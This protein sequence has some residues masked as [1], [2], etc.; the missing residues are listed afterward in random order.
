MI[1]QDF[2]NGWGSVWTLKK[3]EQRIV[4]SLL[5]HIASDSSRTVVIF[6]RISSAGV[7]LAEI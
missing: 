7:S 2:N 4:D 3:F 5:Q 6:L 1:I